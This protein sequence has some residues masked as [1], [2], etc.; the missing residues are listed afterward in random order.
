MKCPVCRSHSL[1]RHTLATGLPAYRCQTCQG[2]W[3]SSSEYWTWLKARPEDISSS[4]E[5]PD[6]VMPIEDVAQVKQCPECG[7]ILRRYKVWPNIKFYLD[8]CGTCGSVWFDNGEW[9]YLKA[10]EKHDQVHIFFTEVWQDKIRAEEMRQRMDA[11]YLE[12]FGAEDYER[13]KEIRAWLWQHPKQAMLMAFLE[14][15]NPYQAVSEP[16]A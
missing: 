2:I 13:I 16:D 12:K 11:M 1:E 4:F 7:H 3:I 8:R 6:V 5:I 10:Q 14:D 15:R 9:D